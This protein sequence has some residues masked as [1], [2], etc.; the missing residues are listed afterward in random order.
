MTLLSNRAYDIL[1]FNAQILLPAIG[2]L[3]F[4]LAQIWGLPKAEEVV[5][6]VTS[7]DVFLGVIL[8][9]AT[10]KYNDSDARYDGAIV[11]EQEPGGPKTFN[12]ELHT[13]NPYALD[14][15]KE[16]IFKVTAPK[17]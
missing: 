7:V 12:L 2:T 14:E 1:K 9:L 15:K 11:V 17:L 8:Q 4:A 5:G 10:K 16:V 6:T 3:Y 13:D